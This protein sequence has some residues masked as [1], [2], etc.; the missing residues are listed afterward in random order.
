MAFATTNPKS[1]SGKPSRVSQGG[2]TFLLVWLL[3]MGLFFNISAGVSNI[4]LTDILNI[5]QLKLFA[6]FDLPI[7]DELVNEINPIHNS[8]IWQLRLPRS[9]LAILAGGGLAVTGVVL[10]AVTRNALADP[11]LLGTSSGASLGA[12]MVIAHIGLFAGHYSLT[13]ASFLGSLLSL[14]FLFSL[15]SKTQ[16]QTPDKIILAGVAISFLLMAA[17]NFLIYLG[18]Q[19]TANAILFWMLG[20]LGRA[21]WDNLLIPSIIISCTTLWLFWQ[22]P[23]LNALMMGSQSAHTLGIPV[24]RY[25]VMLLL[26]TGLITSV[27][28]SLTGSIGFVGLVIPHILRHWV[29]GNNRHIIPLS[30][31]AGAA[32]LLYMDLLARTLSAPQEL[33]IGILSGGIGGAYFC[34]LILRKNN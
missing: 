19:S 28:V 23:I 29:G 27:I 3:L 4:N 32:F 10:Q 14:I 26:S 17:T 13:I 15:L 7:T 25:Q 31:I 18:D 1:A 16:S 12:V 11:F 20:G 8:I 30:F 9:L 6:L 22:A 2:L 5:F 33:P 21:Q 24:K 34:Y